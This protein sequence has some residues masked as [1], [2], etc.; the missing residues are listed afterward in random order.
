MKIKRK[1]AF[2]C[3]LVSLFYCVSLVQS[4]YAKYITSADASANLTIA[5]WNILV[6]DQ[7]IINDSNFSS[8]ITPELLEN[9]NIK[10]GVIAPTSEGYFDITID[11]SETDVSFEYE[12]T[13][14]NSE[15]NT[16]DDLIIEKY[17]IDSIE[18]AYD[19]SLTNTVAYDDE[20]KTVTIRF[21]LKWNDDATTETM[22]NTDDVQATLDGVAAVN[23][24][25]NFTQLRN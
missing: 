2:F 18:T 16:V 25:I 17:V 12:I 21:Y 4:T 1:I 3:A 15:D 5:K 14:D 20:D 10:A 11:A 22:D 8:T 13:V 23:V 9:S 7:D 24:N 6:N 19:G